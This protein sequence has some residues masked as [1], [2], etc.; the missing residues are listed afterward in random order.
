M[1]G[2]EHRDFSAIIGW[3]SLEDSVKGFGADHEFTRLIPD[4]NGKDPDDAFS[5]VPYE[6]GYTFLSHLEGLVGKDKWNQ[7][8]PHYFT[9]Y[10]RLSIDSYE[11]K[12]DLLEFF[13]SDPQASA[14]LKALDWDKWFYS[15]GLP[16]KPD[17]D[18]TLADVCYNLASK[19]EEADPKTFE[20][21][22]KD[23]QGWK[24]NQVVVFLDQLLASDKPLDKNLVQ[25][26]GKTYGLE[27]SSNVEV[28][29]RYYR[30][31][32]RARDEDV[33]QPTAELLANV[34][35]MKFVRPLSVSVK[36]CHQKRTVR[37]NVIDA[38]TSN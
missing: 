32:L 3:K 4:L 21:N 14:T 10:A 27:K 5:S 34:G 6:K 31:A 28:V 20:P 37:A 22:I 15:T 11:F 13:S 35:R 12:T 26:M 19:W 25:A 9:R 24:A 8:I 18:T 33:Y 1:H 23:I 29:A 38:D 16:P 30:V 7:Y 36:F 17:F 2:E